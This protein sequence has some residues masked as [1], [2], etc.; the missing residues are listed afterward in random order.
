VFPSVSSGPHLTMWARR[1]LVVLAAMAAMARAW[2]QQIIGSIGGTG[3]EMSQHALVARIGA[4]AGLSYCPLAFLSVPN[5]YGNQPDPEHQKGLTFFDYVMQSGLPEQERL[6]RL[7]QSIAVFGITSKPFFDEWDEGENQWVVKPFD[8]SVPKRYRFSKEVVAALGIQHVG[9]NAQSKIGMCIA[10]LMSMTT[11]QPTIDGYPLVVDGAESRLAPYYVVSDGQ[12]R[13][14]DPSLRMKP[15]PTLHVPL[16][17]HAFEVR[18]S[19]QLIVAPWGLAATVTVGKVPVVKAGDTPSSPADVGFEDGIIISIRGTTSEKSGLH[20][21]VKDHVLWK[22]LGRGQ[23]YKGA[24]IKEFTDFEQQRKSEGYVQWTNNFDTVL[25]PAPEGMFPFHDADAKVH[26]GLVSEAH[27]LVEGSTVQT[28]G[29]NSFEKKDQTAGL[30]SKAVSWE[31]SD[32]GASV[33]AQ[34]VGGLKD[35]IQDVISSSNLRERTNRARVRVFVGGH[36]KGGGLAILVAGMLAK[37]HRLEIV[38]VTSVEGPRTGNT[39]F[40]KGLIQSLM[41]G[42][43]DFNVF[44]IVRQDDAVPQSPPPRGPSKI[45]A[46]YYAHAPGLISIPFGAVTVAQEP[47]AENRWELPPMWMCDVIDDGGELVPATLGDSLELDGIRPQRGVPGAVGALV[48]K[49]PRK[50]RPGMLELA[51][52]DRCIQFRADGTQESVSPESIT[53][54]QLPGSVCGNLLDPAEMRVECK[55]LNP[56]KKWYTSSDGQLTFYTNAMNGLRKL[57]LRSDEM[58]FHNFV[59]M[60]FFGFPRKGKGLIRGD[61]DAYQFTKIPGMLDYISKLVR[62]EENDARSPLV[63]GLRKLTEKAVIVRR[64]VF[65]RKNL[66]NVPGLGGEIA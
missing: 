56:K 36:S 3:H 24:K 6:E 16:G 13:S 30:R 47:G 45:K 51:N 4:L 2:P 12:L 55:E 9:G 19:R 44:R 63:A 54:G 60:N 66:N 25:I 22:N 15:L 50:V 34:E 38:T 37:D 18:S 46:R 58:L 61:K 42:S 26:R 43:P 11:G 27:R 49:F 41:D 28:P 57:P 21:A 17:E 31:P 5:Y 7:A 52:K 20:K 10:C 64:R 53:A 1:I 33:G 62:E 35:V 32:L 65:H 39:A 23:N 48:N 29:L 40:V 8:A 14:E 59:G